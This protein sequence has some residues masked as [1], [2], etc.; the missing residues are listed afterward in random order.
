M[1]IY[2]LM[3]LHVALGLAVIGVDLGAPID[4][5]T[6][7][8]LSRLLAEHLVLVFPDQALSPEQYLT[9]AA[10]FG[11]PMA[12]DN[13]RDPMPGYPDIG[14]V[15]R[16]NDQ[17]AP[18][19]WHTDH[20]HLERPPAATLFYGVEIPPSGGGTSIA[21]MREA[22]WA[23]SEEERRHIETLRTVNGPDPE[24]ANADAEHPARVIHPMVRTHP[25]NRERAV[26]FHLTETMYIEGMTQQESKEYMA[27]L[28]ERMF[29][30][31]IVYH[32]HWV[33]GDVLVIDDHATW[34]RAGE[35]YG[36]GENRVW[37]KIIIE[38]DRPTL[39]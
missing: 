38:G 25:T 2:T 30:P 23:L 17:P 28:V 3:P 14:L 27:A 32:H 35:D 24:R 18:N 13:S 1:T 5:E 10:A 9:A 7:E 31:D 36:A 21:N 26:Y 22:Y 37:W 19:T 16:R 15:G 29:E 33:K 6:R 11:A 12:Q 20:P 34:Y 8:N 39:A 4:A